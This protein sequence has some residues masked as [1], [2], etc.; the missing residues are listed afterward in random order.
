MPQKYSQHNQS[1]A[2]PW[3]LEPFSFARKGRDTA[4][5]AG[6]EPA[7]IPRHDVQGVLPIKL[8]RHKGGRDGCLPPGE[9]KTRYS[10]RLG[11][12]R[13]KEWKRCIPSSVL[14]RDSILTHLFGSRGYIFNLRPCF[15]LVHESIISGHQINK[16]LMICLGLVISYVY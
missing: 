3:P 7:R 5:L 1:M 4:P 6:V 9:G 8:Q 13:R 2:A 14:H 16:F 11:A 12:G 15:L 10:Y